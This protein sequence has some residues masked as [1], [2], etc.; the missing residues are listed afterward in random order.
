MSHDPL[1]ERLT[2]FFDVPGFVNCDPLPTVGLAFPRPAKS[3]VGVEEVDHHLHCVAGFPGVWCRTAV[4]GVIA[5]VV[6]PAQPIDRNSELKTGVLGDRDVAAESCA[7]V[8]ALSLLVR[9]LVNEASKYRPRTISSAVAA[10]MIARRLA[11][12]RC[13]ARESR[14][15]TSSRGGSLQS[16][17]NLR[18]AAYS[19]DRSGR[20]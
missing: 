19:C 1:V 17:I 13:A 12:R 15:S 14:L 10:S 20:T 2:V 8:D 9:Q 3:S 4:G 18:M 7:F 16:R 6:Q 5:K 11:L